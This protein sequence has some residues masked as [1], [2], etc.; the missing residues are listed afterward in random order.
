MS[1]PYRTVEVRVWDDETGESI[2][3]TF[4]PHRVTAPAAIDLRPK[5]DY[6]IR[7]LRLA[8]QF[9]DELIELD[10]KDRAKD[11]RE[12]Q[13]QTDALN[14]AAIAQERGTK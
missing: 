10:V 2:V 7:A 14:D 4:D 9:C 11:H 8:A 6:A 3:A 1:S 12:R 13:R 5:L